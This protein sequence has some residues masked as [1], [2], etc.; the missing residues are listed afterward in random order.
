MKIKNLKSLKDEYLRSLVFGNVSKNSNRR[1][2]EQIATDIAA[3]SPEQSK[4]ILTDLSD[5]AH[6][7]QE[8]GEKARDFAKNGLERSCLELEQLMDQ[9]CHPE[10]AWIRSY[11]YTCYDNAANDT[12]ATATEQ[13]Q[14]ISEQ[15]KP[16]KKWSKV[17]INRP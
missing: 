1:S 16:V 17:N 7:I 6:T 3:E 15:S 11:I 14:S 2:A 9:V 13:K 4:K 8:A 12:P 5:L 10:Y